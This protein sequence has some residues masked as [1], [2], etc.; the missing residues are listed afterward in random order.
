MELLS[1]SVKDKIELPVTDLNHV[2]EEINKHRRATEEICLYNKER[3][4]RM[5][6]WFEKWK[7]QSKR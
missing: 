7:E 3:S 6:N 2:V 4:Q 5:Q 1:L